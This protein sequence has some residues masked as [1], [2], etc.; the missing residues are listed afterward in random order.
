[1]RLFHSFLLVALLASL[2]GCMTYSAVR[3]ARGK[4]NDVLDY[5]PRKPHPACYALIP[6]SIPA[7]IVTSP[8]QLAIYLYLY[9]GTQIAG[10]T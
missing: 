7:D 6:I 9:V 1:M 2:S 8:V 10:G 5:T 4:R 3:E